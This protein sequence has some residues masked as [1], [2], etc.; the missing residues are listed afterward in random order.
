M[1]NSSDVFHFSIKIRSR[2][3]PVGRA[4]NFHD[5]NSPGNAAAHGEMHPR[6]LLA[7][8]GCKVCR[9]YNVFQVPMQNLLEYQ[10]RGA[11]PFVADQ[12]CDF[13]APDHN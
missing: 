1:K 3:G 13:M 12:N 9:A 10:S 2:G 11:I 8:S 7:F 6:T 5:R 4:F